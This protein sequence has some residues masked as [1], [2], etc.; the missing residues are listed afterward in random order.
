M[1]TRYVGQA[2]SKDR[3]IY[4][5]YFEFPPGF[6]GTM[7]SPVR[8]HI[9]RTLHEPSNTRISDPKSTKRKV[10]LSVPWSLS[11][12]ELIARQ[13]CTL[14]VTFH[15]LSTILSTQSSGVNSSILFFARISTL[16]PPRPSV[17]SAHKFLHSIATSQ[18]SVPNIK[19]WKRRLS[20]SYPPP[21]QFWSGESVPCLCIRR[22]SLSEGSGN[23]D[24]I[25]M[26]GE[27]CQK[28]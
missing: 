3:S 14:I 4:R 27:G 1:S 12:R 16:K 24:A 15:G 8:T 17:P 10:F 18:S 9:C 23:F 26:H 28:L 20:H 21:T 13:N 11:R 2:R 6:S 7:S 25:C 22:Q 19:L 5:D